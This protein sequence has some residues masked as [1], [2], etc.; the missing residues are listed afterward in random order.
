MKQGEKIGFHFLRNTQ[1][2]VYVAFQIYICQYEIK[3]IIINLYFV[4]TP[5]E[6]EDASHFV[7]LG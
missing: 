7:L 4:I 6:I 2:K 1:Y 5:Q 3:K